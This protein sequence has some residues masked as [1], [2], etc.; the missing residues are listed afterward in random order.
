M[1]SQFQNAYALNIIYV[2]V[3]KSVPRKLFLLSLFKFVHILLICPHFLN[4]ILSPNLPNLLHIAQMSS[5]PRPSV[6]KVSHCQINVTEETHID[7]GRGKNHTHTHTHAPVF[8][9]RNR[10]WLFFHSVWFDLTNELTHH[11]PLSMSDTHWHT[12]THC[13]LCALD[14]EV[15]LCVCVLLGCVSASSCSFPESRTCDSER[16]G[17][18]THTNELITWKMN[19]EGRIHFGFF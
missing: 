14:E 8:S 3:S 10:Y 11:R 6:L 2:S 17:R 12:H 18:Q 16:H 15:L 7:S 19:H 9:C 5:S 4:D 13:G 1:S